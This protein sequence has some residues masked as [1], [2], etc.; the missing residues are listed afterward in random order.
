MELTSDSQVPLH[1]REICIEILA[2]DG[3]ENLFEFQK[4]IPA[5]FCSNNSVLEGVKS[6]TNFKFWIDSDPINL[7]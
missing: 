5:N 2:L 4:L 6:Q 3:D 1:C 7:I